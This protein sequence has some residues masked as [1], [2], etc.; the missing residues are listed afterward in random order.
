MSFRGFVVELLGV[1]DWPTTDGSADVLLSVDDWTGLEDPESVLVDPVCIGFDVTPGGFTAI[2]AAGLNED[3]LFHV[4]VV[5]ANHGTGWV[6]GALERLN[7]RHEVLEF[8]CDGYGPSSAIARR[9]EEAG[10]EVR[11]LD[12]NEFVT[13]CVSFVDAVNEKSFRH[14]GQDELLTAVRGARV[15][16]LVDR[17][18]WSRTKSTSDIGSLVASTLA[19]WSAVAITSGP[20]R[21]Y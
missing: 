13:A 18:A 14:L 7:D 21:I 12:T 1:G 19:M 17:W 11:R 3:G 9:V 20:L 4:E 15:R 2:V 6:V 8:V 5:R 16:P 10:I